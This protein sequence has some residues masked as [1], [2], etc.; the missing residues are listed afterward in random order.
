LEEFWRTGVI[1]LF[2]LNYPFIYILLLLFL[3][4]IPLSFSR[5]FYEIKAELLKNSFYYKFC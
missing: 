3:L 2:V 4:T 5:S 1:D